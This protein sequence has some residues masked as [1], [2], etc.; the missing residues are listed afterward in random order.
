MLKL[1]PDMALHIGDIK[2]LYVDAKRLVQEKNV[3]S[4]N[5]FCPHRYA[6]GIFNTAFAV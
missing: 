1:L 2:I 6:V 3:S 5:N 4:E